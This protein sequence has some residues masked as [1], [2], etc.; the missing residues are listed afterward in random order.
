MYNF[1]FFPLMNSFYKFY[2][3]KVMFSY[4][5]SNSIAQIIVNLCV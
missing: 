2:L 5:E 1:H 4:L 3:Y